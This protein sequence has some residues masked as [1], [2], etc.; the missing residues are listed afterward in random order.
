MSA[1]TTGTGEVPRWRGR[2]VLYVAG[3]LMLAFG[4]RGIL[5]N[6]GGDTNP[7][8]WL[9]VLVLAA[10]AHDLVLVPLVSL[11]AVP[12]RRALPGPVGPYVVTG[13]A[14]S[15]VLTAVAWAGLR[16]YGRLRDNPSVLPLDYGRGLLITLGVVWLGLLAGFLV[17][18]SRR[19]R[20]SGPDGRRG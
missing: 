20:S 8:F 11:V 3:I 4:L 16:G 14:L 5:R 7:V 15:G 6:P 13:V 18:R 19:R 2:Y 12:L 17:S 1:A 9:P 10:V